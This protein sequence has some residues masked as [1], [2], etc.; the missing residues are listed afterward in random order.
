MCAGCMYVSTGAL[1]GQNGSPEVEN[2][3]GWEPPDEDARNCSGVLYKDS[4][5]S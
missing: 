5:Y 1:G 4:K 2:K 3:S